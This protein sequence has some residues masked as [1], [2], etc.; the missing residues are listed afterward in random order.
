MSGSELRGDTFTAQDMIALLAVAIILYVWYSKRSQDLEYPPGPPSDPI[1]GHLR[2]I[3][4]T[5]QERTF[6]AWGELYG[7]WT[8]I[9]FILCQPYS[10]Y[11]RSCVSPLFGKE[12]TGSQLGRGCSRSTRQEERIIF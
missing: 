10:I 11:R 4:S 8:A 9:V 2:H 12:N 1:I 5:K 6:A 3:P 7:A